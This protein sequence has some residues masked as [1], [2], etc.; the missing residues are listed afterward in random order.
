MLALVTQLMS[1]PGKK[2]IDSDAEC[3]GPVP[4]LEREEHHIVS[5]E[6]SDTSGSSDEATDTTWKGKRKR[7][8]VLC[9]VN[10]TSFC[11]T[12]SCGRRQ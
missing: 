3:R 12:D 10:N 1:L 8:R 11:V 7:T 6:N 5:V 2:M 4:G 9:G